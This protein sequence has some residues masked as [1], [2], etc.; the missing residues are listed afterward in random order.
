MHRNLFKAAWRTNAADLSNAWKVRK[1]CWKNG[2]CRTQSSN[3]F[4]VSHDFSNYHLR[5]NVGSRFA[6]LQV[7]NALRMGD[8]QRASKIL[9]NIGEVNGYLSANDFACILEYC[10]HTPD[11]LFAMETWKI[12]E[13]KSIDINNRSCGFILQAFSKGG[14]IKEAFD[15]L[16]FLG[17]N[18]RMCAAL[19]IFNILLSGCWSSKSLNYV[20]YC[21]E[22]MDNQLAGKSEVTYWE[23]LKFAVLQR[24]LSTVHKICKEYASYYSPSVIMLRKFIW[25]FSKLGDLKS[26]DASLQYLLALARQGSPSISISAT[27]KYQSSTLDIPIPA[28][29]ML[30]K[31]FW[32]DNLAFLKF[33][34]NLN[35]SL[36]YM[37]VMHTTLPRAHKYE[38]PS[39]T[40]SLSAVQN[41]ILH[42]ELIEKMK[43]GRK[44]ISRPLINLLRWSFNDVI[45]ACAEANKYQLAEHLFLQML[46]FGLKPSRHTYHGFV[47][48]AIKRKE[49]AFCTKVVE[50]MQ[51][52]N[53]QPYN[54]TFALLSIGHSKQLELDLAEFFAD[55]I[56]DNRP[57]Y[58]HTYNALL[59]A[60]SIMD[61]P[62]RAVRL[63]AKIKKLSLKLNIR[64]YELLF[65]LFGTVNSPYEKGN[66]L[67][68]VDVAKRVRAIEVDMAKSGIGH[69]Y[70]SMKNLVY[71]SSRR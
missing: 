13:K 5:N 70:A 42:C 24:N 56:S 53:I 32:L 43:H 21:L 8:R 16:D 27:G 37:E 34:E 19:P 35:N 46:D 47:K 17:E 54:D 30:Y 66:L 61:K 71:K 57:K 11:P 20:N 29:K 65:K 63:L 36:G 3:T 68:Q 2:I 40:G 18:D 14:Y 12:M 62:E 31:G 28:K 55:K 52:R 41:N 33:E 67:S 50:I 22:L 1:R 23:L 10:A 51:E 25:S 48:A 39:C 9:L 38:I 60:C 7:V 45:H 44:M 15:W 69:S 64:T 58:I 6:Q 49:V 59:A 4:P 26:A